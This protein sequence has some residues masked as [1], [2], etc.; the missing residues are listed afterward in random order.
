MLL[1]T[2]TRPVAFR[3]AD[4]AGATTHCHTHCSAGPALAS[5]EWQLQSS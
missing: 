3:H 4:A 2:A 5:Q 1:L